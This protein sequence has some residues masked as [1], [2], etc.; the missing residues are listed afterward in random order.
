[1]GKK[2][3]GWGSETYVTAQSQRK[4]IFFN[5][6]SLDSTQVLSRLGVF[7]NLEVHHYTPDQE[8]GSIDQPQI[9]RGKSD[10]AIHDMF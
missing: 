6:E 4:T 8:S 2:I 9:R 10:V 5:I 3:V 7:E 1:M